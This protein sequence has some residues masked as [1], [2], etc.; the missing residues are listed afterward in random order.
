MNF[1]SLALMSAAVLA[2]AACSEKAKMDG[3]DDMGAY[4]PTDGGM[5]GVACYILSGGGHFMHG[6]GDQLDL[7]HLLL[8]AL[9]GADGDVGGVLGGV[10]DL[11]YR[12]H[13]LTDHH[14]QLAQE[15][16]ETIGDSP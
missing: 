1:R 4:T 2:L 7:L 12:G 10:A 11:L 3:L 14:L 8:H 6:S 16:V 13:H 5:G 15:G 9:V